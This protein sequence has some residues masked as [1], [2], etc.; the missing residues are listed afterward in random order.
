MKS[1]LLPVVLLT[2]WSVTALAQSIA[3]EPERLYVLGDIVDGETISSIREGS[4]DTAGNGASQPSATGTSLIVASTGSVNTIIA[5]RGDA[6]PGGGLYELLGDHTERDGDNVLFLAGNIDA[7]ITNRAG[8]RALLLRNLNQPMAE[9]IVRTNLTTVPGRAVLFTGLNSTEGYGFSAGRI[10]FTGLF[11][12]G[13]A[14]EGVYLW[15]NGTLSTLVDTDDTFQGLPFLNFDDAMPDRN[16]PG[17]VFRSTLDD[18]GSD[19]RAVFVYEGGNLVQLS[20]EGDPY[21]GTAST[22]TDFGTPDIDAGRVAL[23]INGSGGESGVFIIDAQGNPTLVADLNTPLP[24]T[25]AN[26]GSPTF[27]SDRVG[28]TG[29]TVAFNAGRAAPEPEFWLWRDGIIEQAVSAGDVVDGLTITST[30]TGFERHSVSSAGV[31][32]EVRFANGSEGLYRVPLVQAEPTIGQPIPLSGSG[33]LAVL[34]L[35][36][37]GRA[38]RLGPGESSIREGS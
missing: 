22:I 4:I 10:A 7:D 13:S 29:D 20:A 6:A 16:G 28:I 34:L 19:V 31:V 9:I 32:L 25:A 21:P 5:R 11:T 1:L 17:I 24:D 27:I 30:G 8:E 33:L 35:L 38:L 15:E 3:G 12:D 14:G 23:L 36:M 18:G 26:T 2:S 37:G